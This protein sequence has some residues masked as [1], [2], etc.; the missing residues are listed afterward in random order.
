MCEDDGRL[1]IGM[2][3]DPIYIDIELGFCWDLDGSLVF[4]KRVYVWY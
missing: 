4:V 1:G 3:D 2:G